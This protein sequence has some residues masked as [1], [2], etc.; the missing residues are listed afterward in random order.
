MTVP[1]LVE[2]FAA[3]ALEQYEARLDDEYARYNRLYDRM[4]AV[5][6]ELKGRPA[7]QRRAL[8]PLLDHANPQVRLKSAVATLALAPER[9][10]RVLQD[11]VDEKE[12]PEAADAFGMLRALDKGT[13]V[14]S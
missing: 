8:I 14:P 9:S 13:Y 12:Y 11:L 1:Q 10:R 4:A 2:R 5:I 6:A 3:I 7:D